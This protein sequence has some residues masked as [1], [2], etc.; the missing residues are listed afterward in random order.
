MNVLLQVLTAAPLKNYRTQVLGGVVFV[1]AVANWLVGDMS[2]TD[3][4]QNLPAMVGGLGLSALGAKVNGVKASQTTD[5]G[6][7]NTA[8]TS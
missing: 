4:L 7:S 1:S 3:L 8:K 6:A 5:T 2:L